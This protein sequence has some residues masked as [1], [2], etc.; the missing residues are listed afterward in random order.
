LISVKLLKKGDGLLE[1][2][3]YEFTPSEA[4]LK[5]ARKHASNHASRVKAE[6]D[7]NDAKNAEFLRKMEQRKK[8][9]PRN[10]TKSSSLLASKCL[11]FS[12]II[13]CGVTTGTM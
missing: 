13:M 9:A 5:A 8:N 2:S 4:I 11:V 12:I 1:S 3:T 10:T 7:W 6:K